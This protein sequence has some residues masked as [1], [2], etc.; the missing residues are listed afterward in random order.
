MVQ[1][2]KNIILCII[3]SITI[4]ICILLTK[5]FQLDTYSKPTII[6]DYRQ[7]IIITIT[8]LLIV[9]IILYFL[10]RYITILDKQYKSIIQKELDINKKKIYQANHDSLTKLPN[11]ALFLKILKN[12][13]KKAKKDNHKVAIFFIDLD[14]FKQINDS[15]GHDI[16]DEVLKITAKRLKSKIRSD[17]I[18]ARLGG[19]EFVAIIDNYHQT[20][21]LKQI[22]SNI[23]KTIQ[24]PIRINEHILYISSSIGISVYPDDATSPKDLLKFA[25]T[26]MYQVKDEGRNGYKFYHP[27]MTQETYKKLTI[28]S[29]LKNALQNDEFIVCLQPQIDINT[30]KLIGLEALSRWNHPQRGFLYPSEY[31]ELA[32]SSGVIIDIDRVIMQKAMD[33]FSRWYKEGKTPGTLSVNITITNI[34]QDDFID[35][36][37]SILSTYH[38]KPSWLILEV[39]ENEVMQK[40][41]IVSNRLK[42]LSDMGISITIDDFGVG[43]SSLSYLKQLPIQKIKIDRSF[44]FHVPEENDDSSI[45]KAIIALANNLNLEIMAEGVETQKQKEFLEENGCTSIQGFYYDK[46]MLPEQIKEKYLS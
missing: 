18:L 29:E 15:L 30:N 42:Q 26:A 5:I 24:E 38:F 17:D 2:I 7:D 35:Y 21:D 23:I 41:E 43:Y 45:V 27:K 4:Y 8:I 37:K 11:R 9:G 33:I 32:I 44:M 22:A 34:M 6:A 13:I 31:I 16:G 28:K 10:K 25:D 46:P 14:Q 20:S 40:H 3:T 36:I 1:Y 39:A 12:T 19:D